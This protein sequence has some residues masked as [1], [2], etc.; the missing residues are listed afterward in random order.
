[1]S[2]PVISFGVQGLISDSSR[3]YVPMYQR[4][5]AWGEGEIHQL[6]QDVQDMQ[7]KHQ[8]R[9]VTPPYY[10]GTLVVFKRTDGTFEV[11]DGQQR[12]TTLT[13]MAICLKRLVDAGKVSFV[14]DWFEQPNLAFESR[15]KS[16]HTLTCLTQGMPLHVLRNE[17]CNLDLL[18]G[19]EL[20]EKHLLALGSQ[21]ESFC[22]YL[23]EQVKITRVSVPKDTDLNHYFE[24]MNSRG[25]QLEKHEVIKARLM[26]V[27]HHIDDKAQRHT[28]LNALVKVWDA[29]ANMEC[30]V[31]YGFT[32]QQRHQLFGKNWGQFKPS[33]FTELCQQMEGTGEQSTSKCAKTL[34]DILAGP[35]A[36]VQKKSDV[37]PLP[38]RF[39]SVIN[40]SNFLLHVLRIWTGKDIPLDDKQLID[41][42]DDHI[43]KSESPAQSVQSFVFAL[44]K[45][46]YLFDQYIIKRE[47]SDGGD[48]WSLKRLHCYNANSQSYINT[49]DKRVED[50]FEGIN[51]RILM[52]LSALHVST[53]TMVYKHWLNGALHALY[54]MESISA[55]RYLQKLEHM[56]RQFVFGRYLNTQQGVEYYEMIYQGRGYPT[57]SVDDPAMHERLKYGAIENNLVFNYLD[58]LIWC[59]EMAKLGA[60]EVI[61]RFEFTSRS[62]VEHFSPQHPMEGHTPLPDWALHRFGNLCL[63]S[64]SKN[65]RLSNYQPKAKR[66]HFQAAIAD[67]KVDSLKLYKMIRLMDY[68][69][70]W[71][72]AQIEQHE[73]EMVKILINDAADGITAYVTSANASGKINTDWYC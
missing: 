20:L 15:V 5:Y 57:L 50:G 35:S 8:V 18:N 10:I 37:G 52:L 60:D 28:S 6:I 42:F 30:Y 63:I 13:L 7:Y 62:S 61:K 49:F 11:I 72:E 4:N 29:T 39:S 16:S 53:P 31:Q 24:V 34:H 21:L 47:F 69:N 12:F 65:S 38:E 3:Y 9:D 46:K 25:E 19:F 67:R 51:R 70:G 73:Q 68:E 44:L 2:E 23:F 43:I 48:Q 45:T 33:N 1:M 55:S 56:A 36:S 32:P 40:F 54:W 66:D 14:M 26:S 17:T 71:G 59:E 27:L 41:Q 64:H 58:Y 22:T